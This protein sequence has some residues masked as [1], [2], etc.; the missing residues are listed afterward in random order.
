MTGNLRQLL[1]LTIPHLQYNADLTSDEVWNP[2]HPEMEK[3]IRD[4]IKEVKKATIQWSDIEVPETKEEDKDTCT[5]HCCVLHGCKY[6]K[7]DCPVK[8]RLKKQSHPCET[9]FFEE[10]NEY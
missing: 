2:D 5:E 7:K 3:E 8:N 6:S 1:R 10:E 4:L 9:C